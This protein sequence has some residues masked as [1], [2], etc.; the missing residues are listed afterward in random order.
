MSD[1]SEKL[2]VQDI[3][4]SI[5]RIKEYTNDLSFDEFIATQLVVDAVIR[6]FAVIG[7]AIAR[8]PLSLKKKNSDIP[9]RQ[10]KDFRNRIIHFYFG[11]DYQII[12]DIITN[13]LDSILSKFIAL[14]D[15]LPDSLFDTE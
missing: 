2:L 10:I 8:L 5:T 11:I 7:E 6:N 13:E 14:N 12:W 9:F 15:S 1:R 4:L 3:I